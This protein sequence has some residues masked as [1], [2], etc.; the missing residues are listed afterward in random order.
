MKQNRLF[1]LITLL[2]ALLLPLTGQAA[3]IQYK[4]GDTIQDFS[5]TTY[6][7]QQ[8]SI[9]EVLKEKDAILL[10]IWASWCNPCR[11]EFPFMQEAY[12]EYRDQVEII[13]LSCESTDT[14]DKLES[15]AQENGLTFLI[16]Q[17]PEAL[18][19][20]VGVSSIP[21]SLMIDRYG[22]ICFMEAGAQPDTDSF[23]RLFDAFV[24]EDYQESLLLAS[25][26]SEKPDVAASSPEELYTALGCAAS[27]PSSKYSWPMVT[28]EK[29]GR[30]VLMS[31][32]AGKASSRAEVV[33]EVEAEAGDAIVITFK[34]STEPLYDLLTIA[35]NGKTVKHFGGEHDWMTYAIPVEAA[36]TQAV[37]VSY[38]K[39]RISDAGNDTVWLDS[40]VV[41]KDAQNAIA[42]NP[43]YPVFPSTE[44]IPVDEQAKEV[45][46]DDPLG[47]LAANFGDVRSFVVN[48]DTAE[49]N[50]H[51]AEDVDPECALVYF[52][53]DQAQIPVT[54]LLATNG[55]AASTKLDSIQT[56]GAYCT[57][58]VIYPDVQTGNAVTTLLFLDEENLDSFVTRNSLGTWHY[59]EAAE[60]GGNASPTGPV[61][62]TLLCTDQDGAPVAGAM[63]QVCN[64]EVCQVFMTD[65]DGKAVFEA[66]AYPW[67]IHVL[68]APQEYESDPSQV[69][70]APAEGGEVI[71]RLKKK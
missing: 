69:M 25:I 39:D 40:I 20:A 56:T 59:K 49:V 41:V 38:V 7:G 54:Q 10:N 22:T 45:L 33:A 61:T 34:T 11:R 48:A 21:V 51:L 55:Y 26:P 28:T 71:I 57:F 44:I 50:I 4:K 32:N 17:A 37:K 47:L 35:L 9:Y 6:N 12:E 27:N 70:I 66:E 13:A 43:F 52:S 5:F 15:F 64:D 65:A 42:D 1:V 46:I 8:Y 16:G 67:E 58:A 36:G 63:L 24:G 19:E 62:Y 14:P 23:R 60:G 30:Q 29:D 53:Y 18:L 2:A 68:K 3:S 31:T